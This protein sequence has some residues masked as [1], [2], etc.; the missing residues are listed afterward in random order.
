MTALVAYNQD[1]YI[2]FEFGDLID[3]TTV[4]IIWSIFEYNDNN[5]NYESFDDYMFL[6]SDDIYYVKI[7]D[8]KLKPQCDYKVNMTLKSIETNLTVLEESRLFST[9]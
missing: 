4:T 5:G 1:V 8:G 6:V 7:P 2:S 3:P 9:P